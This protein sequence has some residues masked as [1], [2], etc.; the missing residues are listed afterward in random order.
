M[1]HGKTPEAWFSVSLN[2]SQQPLQSEQGL[3]KELQPNNIHLEKR[4]VALLRNISQRGQ[5]FHQMIL[6]N[7]PMRERFMSSPQMISTGQSGMA[8]QH[9]KALDRAMSFHSDF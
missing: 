8:P 5:R 7:N 4:F 3:A 6:K 1:P 2:F 9:L